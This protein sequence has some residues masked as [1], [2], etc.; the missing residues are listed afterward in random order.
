[1]AGRL[2][3]SAKGKEC[4][5]RIPFTCNHNPETTVLAHIRRAG[6]AGLGIKPP[7]VCGVLCCSS[8]H[9]VIDGR[10]KAPDGIT[11]AMV[12]QMV[13]DGHL[14]TLDWWVRNGYLKEA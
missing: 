13:F 8:C 1:M 6:I 12:L 14:R 11:D 7:D 2:R 5:I 10:T 3:Q 9:D 4:E